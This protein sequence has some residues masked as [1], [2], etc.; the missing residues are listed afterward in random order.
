LLVALS[1]YGQEEDRRRSA[2]AGIDHHLIK[3][4]N[5]NSLIE[6]IGRHA[7]PHD[8]NKAMEGRQGA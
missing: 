8:A 4:A 3:P 2:T 7:M 1:G 6:L 5:L